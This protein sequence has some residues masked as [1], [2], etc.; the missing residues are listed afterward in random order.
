MFK[1]LFLFLFRSFKSRSGNTE[2]KKSKSKTP[3]PEKIILR[4]LWIKIDL[5]NPSWKAIILTIV[6]LIAVITVLYLMSKNI[7]LLDALQASKKLLPSTISLK[8]L[9]P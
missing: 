1:K 9:S 2:P 6:F 4:F 8:K 5:T 7:H 3:D